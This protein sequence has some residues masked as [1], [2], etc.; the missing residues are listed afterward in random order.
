MKSIVTEAA[1]A[2]RFDLWRPRLAST[3]AAP[4]TA[5]QLAESIINHL[6]VQCC[7]E[8]DPRDVERILELCNARVRSGNGFV[9]ARQTNSLPDSGVKSGWLRWRSAAPTLRNHLASSIANIIIHNKLGFLRKEAT[10]NVPTLPQILQQSTKCTITTRNSHHL[11][12]IAC[13]SRSKGSRTHST[14]TTIDLHA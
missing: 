13:G 4:G 8:A 3:S 7:S 5:H 6:P 11:V 2:S 9:S 14:A 1:H 12:R 10:M